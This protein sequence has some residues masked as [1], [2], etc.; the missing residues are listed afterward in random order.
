MKTITK[1]NLNTA[2]KKSL[3]LL[4]ISLI[5][6]GMM[7]AQDYHWANFDYH[8]FTQPMVV[9]SQVQF[10]GEF[11]N[12][13]DIE[14]AAF[15][16]DELRG[17]TFLFEP[18][19][20]S[21]IAGQYFAYAPCYYDS[22]GETFTF[23]AYDHSAGLEYDICNTEL[24]G[25]NDGH[26]TVESPIILDFTRIEEPTYGP[27][28]PW[29]PSTQYGGEGMVV[30]AQIQINGQLVD[31]ATYEVGAFCGDECRATS[32]NALDDWT[33]FNL[34]Y[35]AF[36]NVMGDD[37]DTINFY[38]YDK[39]GGFIF[40]GMCVTT[41][42]LVNGGELGIDIFGG[43]LFIL[44]FVTV[45]TFTKNIDGYTNDNDCYYLIAS[46]ITQDVA[47]S[48]ENGF[49]TSEFD[50]YFFNHDSVD[51]EW[52]NYKMEAF[53]LTHGKG[54]LYAS[55][56]STT[57]T[58]TGTPY[59][60]DGEIELDYNPDVPYFGGW[61]LV[62]NPFAQ[63]AFVDR[64]FYVLNGTGTEIAPAEGNST[65]MMEG[66]FVVADHDGET[67]TF[68]TTAPAKGA[69]LVMNIIQ[70]RGLAIDRAIIRFDEGHFLGKYQLNPNHTKLYIPQDN[71][72]YAVVS[73]NENG[74]MPINFKAE[75][76]GTYTLSVSAQEMDF[77]YLH[78]IDNL[79]GADVDLLANP[80]YTFN[81]QTTDY[82]SRFKL[83]FVCGDTNDDHFAI[84]SNG[85]WVIDNDGKAILQVIDVNGRVLSSE[86][87]SGCAS[88]NIDEAA[89]VYMMRLIKGDNV[90]VQ[91]IV[92]R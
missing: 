12:R 61:N 66:I 39:D 52:Q 91:K 92:V 1:T 67:V 24:V 5:F 55:Q 23:K 75:K 33:D 88:I 22:P 71:K 14:V 81:A 80:N 85:S 68:S 43:G 47:P 46:P 65:E 7:Y 41:V 69:A 86:H 15:V 13:A 78:L 64:D 89:G 73:A 62:G 36:M 57:L 32:G 2:M 90:K 79:T 45:Q 83:V 26:G 35:F 16:G 63:T 50:L 54:Y 82:A 17:R 44:N 56:E 74:E 37:G 28:Y 21:P 29:I 31:R 70:N 40:P 59:Y 25:Q 4:V 11:Q 10:N 84:F 60:G 42:E 58:F 38:L 18:Y 51:N 9:I 34:G 19:P 77:R 53:S 72:A 6:S 8:D 49:I 76:N 48:A 20:N 87:I 27:D 30:T 3:I